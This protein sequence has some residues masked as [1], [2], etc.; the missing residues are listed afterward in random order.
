M[1]T[2]AFPSTPIDS[3]AS[4]A[5][6]IQDLARLDPDLVARVLDTGTAPSLR[7]RPAGFEG[8]A[9]IIVAQQISTA[10][11]TAIFG[12]LLRGVAPFEPAIMA[13]VSDEVLQACGLSRPKVKTLRALAEAL[14]TGALPLGRMAHMPADEALAALVSIR[15]IGPWTAEVFML[16]C[17]G[18]GDAWPAGDL[19]LQEAARML[20]GLD[21]RPNTTGLR[22][23]GERWR[24]YRG[25]AAYLLWTYYK[26]QKSRDGI[27]PGADAA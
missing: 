4:L 18:H 17:L 9:R 22:L 15:G 27:G 23:I 11:A 19:A 13:A 20:L 8:L 25:A 7:L 10:S 6:A 21:R 16:F 3:E 1:T 14:L 26:A 2:S 5:T 24:P 12:R